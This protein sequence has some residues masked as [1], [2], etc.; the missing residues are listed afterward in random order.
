MNDERMACSWVVVGVRNV[1]P[2]DIQTFDGGK[3]LPERHKTLNLFLRP[4][5]MIQ[6]LVWYKPQ[7]TL[8]KTA[9]SAEIVCGFS[10]A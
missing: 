10:I 6:W 3:K 5:S 1:R 4:K 7:V 8:E 9:V 2:R